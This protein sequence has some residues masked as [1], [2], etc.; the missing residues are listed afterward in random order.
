MSPRTRYDSCILATDVIYWHQVRG[1][2]MTDSGHRELTTGEAARLAGV[3][4]SYIRRLLLDGRLAGRQPDGWAWLVDRQ[5]FDRWQAQRKQRQ[6][7]R[8]S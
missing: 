6:S 5:S 1:E 3:T 2:N 8:D 7:E 4:T